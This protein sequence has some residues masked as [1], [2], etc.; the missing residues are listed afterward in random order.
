M[1]LFQSIPPSALSEGVFNAG[2]GVPPPDRTPVLIRCGGRG[3]AQIVPKLSTAKVG[4][5]QGAQPLPP[6]TYARPY[7]RPGA[8]LGTGEKGRRGRRQGGRHPYAQAILP[9]PRPYAQA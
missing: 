6:I 9:T 2:L 3:A 5:G 4:R 1:V 7:A 8:K